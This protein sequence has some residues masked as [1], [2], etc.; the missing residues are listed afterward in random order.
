MK[1][2]YR[3]P[4][5]RMVYGESVCMWKKDNLNAQTVYQ[6]LGMSETAYRVFETMF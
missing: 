4:K 2:S 5:V 1:K 3:S 6:R